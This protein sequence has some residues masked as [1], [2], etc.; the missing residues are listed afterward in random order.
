MSATRSEATASALQGL[1][2]GLARKAHALELFVPI[3]SLSSL[4][5]ELLRR[6]ELGRRS[7]LGLED[8]ALAPELEHE[9][10]VSHAHRQAELLRSALELCFASSLEG[11]WWTAPSLTPPTHR[12][13]LAAA[14]AAVDDALA[15][16]A[17]LDAELLA[18]CLHPPSEWSRPRVLA[19]AAS[20]LE[21]GW[22]GRVALLRADLLEGPLAAG[23]FEELSSSAL[24]LRERARIE[25]LR[26]L[27]A[28]RE[29]ELRRALGHAQRSMLLFPEPRAA[30]TA[31]VLATELRDDSAAELAWRAMRG[32]S[33]ADLPLGAG[34]Q[35]YL[36]RELRA[37][38]REG[39]RPLS[40]G[41]RHSFESMLGSLRQREER[42]A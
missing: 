26:G 6:R 38:R 31:W 7:L 32:A 2:E 18:C 33:P 35:T 10:H 17:D 23:R 8:Q 13:W 28:E 4:G 40:D 9:L 19:A 1:L 20:A 42:P 25:L 3:E 41:L 34:L 16:D 39:G 14:G 30:L 27:C 36:W 5:E 21:P 29:G 12:A 15:D 22:R 11:R 24:P 37:R